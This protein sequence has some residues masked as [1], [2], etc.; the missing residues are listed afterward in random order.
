METSDKLFAAA[1][2]SRDNAYAPYSNFKVGAAIL[3][4]GNKIY[5]GCN[6]ENASFPCGNCAEA[7]AISSMA[8]DGQYEIAAI[9]IVADTEC[10][11]PCGNCLQ[12]IAEFATKKTVVYSADIHGNIRTYTLQQLLPHNFKAGDMKC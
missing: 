3:T 8:A 2:K 12:K 6:V 4:S 11:L 9:L 7:G 10:I 1:L 5:T